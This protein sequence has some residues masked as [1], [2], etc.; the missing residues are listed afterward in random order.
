MDR[1]RKGYIQLYCGNGKGKTTAALGLSLRTLLSGGSVFF[2][3]F[4][5]GAAT[6]EMELVSF[7][8]RFVIEQYGTGNFIIGQPTEEDQKNAR[9]GLEHC[10]RVLES[11]YFDLVIL[12]EIILSTFYQII[13]ASEIINVIQSRKPWV[14]VVLTGRK[15]PHELIE[16]ADLVTEMRKVKHYFDA[17]V[18]AR[19]GI[20]F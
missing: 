8:D 5:K 2:A 1:E 16:M 20:E 7:C 19:K 9:N 17:G 11:G 12:D 13:T 10:K 6:A 18:K 4:F 3:Q 14:E 15:A